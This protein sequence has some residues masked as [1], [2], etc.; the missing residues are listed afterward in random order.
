MYCCSKPS[1][2]STKGALV[3]VT[4]LVSES[5]LH[6]V[7]EQRR[8]GADDDGLVAGEDGGG[9]GEEEL[10]ASADV[11]AVGVTATCILCG[12]LNIGGS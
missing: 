4:C 5:L 7:H 3:Q 9:Q 2:T 6:S 11:G 1:S 12:S 8:E 10:E